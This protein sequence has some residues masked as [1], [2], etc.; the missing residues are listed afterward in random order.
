VLT[1]DS[2]TFVK[3]FTIATQPTMYIVVSDLDLFFKND[4]SITEKAI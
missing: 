3:K 1:V 4:R 2:G